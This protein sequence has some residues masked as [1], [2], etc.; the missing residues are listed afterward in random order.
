MGSGFKKGQLTFV[1]SDREAGAV[2]PFG[3]GTFASRMKNPEP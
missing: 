3:T 1:L 2:L